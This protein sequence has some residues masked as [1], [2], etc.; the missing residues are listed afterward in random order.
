MFFDQIV[1]F[2]GYLNLLVQLI[3]FIQLEKD[4]F[5]NLLKIFL[6]K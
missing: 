2:L 3:I 5:E 6:K 1:F 4:K